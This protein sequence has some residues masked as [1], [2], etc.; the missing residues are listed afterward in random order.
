[1]TRVPRA[2]L[3]VLGGAVLALSACA[4]EGETPEG[5]DQTRSVAGRIPDGC[6]WWK[7]SGY[8]GEPPTFSEGRWLRRELKDFGLWELHQLLSRPPKGASFTTDAFERVRAYAAAA[9]QKNR[10]QRD[11][12]QA[13][14]EDPALPPPAASVAEQRAKVAT[15][16]AALEAQNSAVEAI[17]RDQLAA[18]LSESGF[19]TAHFLCTALHLGSAELESGLKNVL[20]RVTGKSAGSAKG[21]DYAGCVK[22]LGRVLPSSREAAFPPP[23]FSFGEPPVFLFV[24]PRTSLDSSAVAMFDTTLDLSDSRRVE[25]TLEGRC[26]VSAYMAQVGGVAVLPTLVG[27]NNS[28]SVVPM[29]VTIA[30]EWTHVYLGAMPLG[31]A[32]GKSY[33][34]KSV[35]ETVADLVGAELAELMARRHYPVEWQAYDAPAPTDQAPEFNLG[36]ARSDLR[37]Q[38]EELLGQGLVKEA[39][40]TMEAERRSW[41]AHTDRHGD[42]YWVRRVNQAYLGFYGAYASTDGASRIG[43]RLREL[44]RASSSLFAFLDRVS[45]IDS[46]EPCAGCTSLFPPAPSGR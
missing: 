8:E 12:N 41:L 40:E 28:G 29:L 17:L 26:D 4:P 18:A 42:R 25:K 33:D 32:Y 44:R 14:S 37:V 31:R 45:R 43:A 15:A 20:Y 3:V 7:G 10:L 35:N 22:V 11:L 16:R 38:V 24:S 46:I 5:G 19:F 2:V 39:E 1:M 21:V 6:D 27:Y 23:L 30:H 36:K 9:I 34:L 13:L